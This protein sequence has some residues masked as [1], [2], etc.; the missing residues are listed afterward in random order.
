M[1]G[2][3]LYVIFIEQLLCAAVHAWDISENKIDKEACPCG[4]YK[5]ER[6]KVNIISFVKEEKIKPEKGER[7]PKCHGPRW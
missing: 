4:A 2:L 1:S 6:Q 3:F 5:E 7:G